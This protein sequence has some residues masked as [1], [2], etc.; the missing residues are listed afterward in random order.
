MSTDKVNTQ[1]EINYLQSEAKKIDGLRL[2]KG[3]VENI[4]PEINPFSKG[5]KKPLTEAQIN[6]KKKQLKNKVLKSIV[7]VELDVLQESVYDPKKGI[8]HINEYSVA[9]K[10]Q[11]Q[12]D[13]TQEEDFNQYIKAVKIY[14][15]FNISTILQGRLE[16]YLRAWEIKHREKT[17][18]KGK[19][20]KSGHLLDQS[21]KYNYPKDN[22]P[23]LELFNSTIEDIKNAGVEITEVVEG[24]K[25]SPSEHKVIDSLCKLLHN[26]SQTTDPKREDYYAGNNGLEIKPYGA[27]SKTVVPKIATTLYELTK[28]YKGEEY[29]SGKDIENVKQIL[30]ELDKRKFL[31]R[32]KEE[33]KGKGGEWIKKEYETFRPL[34]YIDK[35]TLSYGIND[36]ETYKKE[37]TVIVLNPIFTRQID[38][39]FVSYPNDINRRTMIAYGSHN[40]SEIA[41]RLRDYLVR[42][43]SSKRYEPEISLDRLYHFLAEK[44]MKESRKKKVKEYTEKALDTVKALGLLISYEEKRNVSG[45]PKI[46]FKLNKSWE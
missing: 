14:L 11:Y 20:K 10:I 33:T 34:I 26:N 44:W 41:L 8:K 18:P 42:E 16:S 6:R 1:E 35:A 39:K 28:E 32:Y 25:L 15:D 29:V 45:E 38:K 23:Q 43:L 19:F 12:K 9:V 13:E 40:I 27:D 21:L 7:A 31:I 36:V 2:L 30:T 22:N 5:S 3:F 24:I 4:D 46:V 37:E 17:S